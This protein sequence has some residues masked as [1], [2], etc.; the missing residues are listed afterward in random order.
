MPA[1][2][3]TSPT[4][5][6]RAISSRSPPLKLR[7]SLV[8][9]LATLTATPSCEGC[10]TPDAVSRPRLH[11]TTVR[12]ANDGWTYDADLLT[13]IPQPVISPATPELL[14]HPGLTEGWW[15]ELHQA[16]DVL[17]G[18][19]TEREAVRTLWIRRLPA[20]P[21]HR[22]PGPRGAGDRARDRH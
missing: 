12:W 15:A 4:A 7:T 5:P 2:L 14:A 13:H 9:P 21:R 16:L 3:P 1:L 18:V 6:I 22:R 11:A 20:V 19:P 10:L 17:A 8:S